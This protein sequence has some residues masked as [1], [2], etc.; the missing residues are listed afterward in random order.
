M[1]G[2][3]DKFERPK[4]LARAKAVL[5]HELRVVIPPTVFFFVGFNP[6]GT[7]ARLR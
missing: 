5:L 3:T 7:N 2:D 1:N 6:L 4:G